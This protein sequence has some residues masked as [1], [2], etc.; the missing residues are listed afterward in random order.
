MDSDCSLTP[1]INWEEGTQEYAWEKCAKYARLTHVKTF[2]FDE[3]GNEPSV[4]IPKAMKILL[5][6][7]YDGAWG[8]ES[9]PRILSEKEGTTK[10]LELMKG[11]L[12][13]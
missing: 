12:G 5:D 10:T 9:C 11:V 8:I 6:A 13:E 1:T 4:D 2:E 3:N 7:G